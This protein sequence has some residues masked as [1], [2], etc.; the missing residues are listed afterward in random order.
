[1]SSQYEK[2]GREFPCVICG[3]LSYRKAS[4]FLRKSPP[5][6][7]SIQCKGKHQSLK[8]GE[9][10]TRW[11][12][13]GVGYYGLHT[14]VKRLYGAADRCELCDRSEIPQGKKKYFHWANISG[15]YDSDKRDDWVKAC[16]KCHWLMDSKRNITTKHRYDDQFHGIKLAD[17]IPGTCKRFQNPR[18]RRRE[19][20][21]GS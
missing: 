20:S 4:H 21:S 1:M 19:L 9:K 14:R 13:T 5:I 17:Y 6:A 18:R 10:A 15:K 16:F 12:G 7:C 11:A 3:K 8:T 2:T